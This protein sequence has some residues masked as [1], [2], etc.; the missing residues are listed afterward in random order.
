[1]KKLLVSNLVVCIASLANAGPSISIDDGV[2]SLSYDG[3]N[4][5]VSSN[6]DLLGGINNVVGTIG[7][8]PIGDF[9]LRTVDVPNT[10]AVITSYAQYAA[11][12]GYDDLKEIVWSN[13]YDDILVPS[14][15]GFWFSFALPGYIL[16]EE[17]QHSIQVDLANTQGGDVV[18]VME[19]IFLGV[20]EPA[21]MA[22]LGL[23]GLFITRRK[24]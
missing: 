8:S 13:N 7:H 15:A 6:E 17:G 12:Y 24:K 14:P 9:T 16:V 18:N 10:A 22:L 3:V 19:S 21:T 4:V 5:S 2:L 20:P 23:G 1:M 11:T